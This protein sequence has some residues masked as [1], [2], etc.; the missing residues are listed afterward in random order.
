VLWVSDK[1]R[2]QTPARWRQ[3]YLERDY[4]GLFPLFLRGLGPSYDDI[5]HDR[6]WRSGEL[7]P[8]TV[9]EVGAAHADAVIRERWRR[10]PQLG[11]W[12]GVAP[13]LPVLHDPDEC[14]MAVADG[15]RPAMLGLVRASSGSAALAACGWRGA[16]SV[17]STAELAAIVASWE[18]RFA[19]TV[20]EVGY[21]SLT[22]SVAAPPSNTAEATPVAYEHLAIAPLSLCPDGEPVPDL[23][24]YRASLV[25]ST[26]WRL[27]WEVVDPLTI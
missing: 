23:D 12:S 15:M 3:L 5:F 11:L 7:T 20:L 2:A 16:V 19:V 13:A 1:L 22:L 10:T 8:A 4:S 18:S 25:D 27:R 21:A 24:G 26:V 9:A 17:A 6:P 14:A